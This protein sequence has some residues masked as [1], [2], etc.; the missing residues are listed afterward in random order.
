MSKLALTLV[1]PLLATAALGLSV[2]A[3]ADAPALEIVPGK[4]SLRLGEERQFHARLKG[5]DVTVRWSVPD[6]ASG[7]VTTTGLYHAPDT[8][9]TPATLHVSGWVDA[10]TR[11]ECLV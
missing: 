11:A 7:S 2:V 10:Y 3:R 5:K 9:T 1:L 8:A 4:L 6:A